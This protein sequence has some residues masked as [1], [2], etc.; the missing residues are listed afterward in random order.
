MKIYRPFL[1]LTLV[2]LA[3]I[4]CTNKVPD[5]ER[6][7]FT[8]NNQRIEVLTTFDLIDNY[9]SHS[10]KFNGNIVK[11]SDKYIY[12]PIHLF[13]EG[14]VAIIQNICIFSLTKRTYFAIHIVFVPFF[15]IF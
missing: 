10:G 7:A 14:H 11:S 6:A 13:F 4:G 1:S 3:V 15:N 8:I 2:G 12:K 9:L 5:F